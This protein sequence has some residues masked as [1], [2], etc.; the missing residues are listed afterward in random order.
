VL[1]PAR[2]RSAGLRPVTTSWV[3]PKPLKGMAVLCPSNNRLQ[4]TV[5]CAARRR[6]G[7]LA[8]HPGCGMVGS[9]STREG[10]MTTGILRTSIAAA[11]LLAAPVASLAQRNQA[12]DPGAK[13]TQW[14]YNAGG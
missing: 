2:P 10:F 6:T 11:L 4:R 7:A 1:I 3:A 12:S 8:A 5:R 13:R 9:R 14:E